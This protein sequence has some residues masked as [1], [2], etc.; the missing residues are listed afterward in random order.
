MTQVSDSRLYESLATRIV[1]MI[2]G[3][4]LRLGDKV[5]SVR[6]ISAQQNVSISTA[7]HAYRVLENQ[8]W[9]E[10]R[11]QSGYY[12]RRTTP[13]RPPEP[14]TTQPP[15]GSNSVAVS[16]LI[17]QAFHSASLSHMIQ[18]GAA[19]GAPE[20]FPDKQLRRA[21][22][23]VMRDGE[24]V[25]G[26]DFGAG[27]LP[28]RV[29]IAQHAMSAGCTLSPD[30]IIVTTGCTEAIN[31]CLRAVT[32]P[33]DTVVLE[34]PTYYSVLQIIESLGLRALELPTNPREGISLDALEYV[35]EHDN[36]AACLL[37]PS[38][39]NPLGHCMPDA[40][41]Q[42]LVKMLRARE[43]PLIEDDVWGDTAFASTRP[44]AAKSCDDD[45]WVLY[46][47]S[48]SKTVAPGY[49]IGW[50]A[51]GRWK[52]QVEY[53]K[54]VS[55]CSNASLPSRILAEFLENGGYNHHLRWLRRHSQQ[56]MQHAIEGIKKYFPEGTCVTHPQGGVVLWVELPPDVD[57]LKLCNEALKLGISYAP[58]AIFSATK[59][60][61]NALR[62]YCGHHSDEQTQRALQTLGELFAR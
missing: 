10:A 18:M 59:K 4:A 45:G 31:L 57:T 25:H 16:D 51:P 20:T 52:K 62:L 2:E 32:K 26:Y 50:V 21:I 41:K 29:Q 30:D 3:G 49:R 14:Q 27:Y 39:Q 61:R 9:I 24:G 34:S 8:G 22:S 60:Y 44:H 42:R 58:G 11:P 55:S 23:T 7:L 40:N 1:E 54:L 17:R 28:L 47:S 46:C 5:P 6:K 33:G 35:L 56:K 36:V 48:F 53:L 13:A 15:P 43:I 12:V 19:I 38:F 37:M